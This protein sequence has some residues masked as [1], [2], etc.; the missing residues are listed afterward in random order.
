MP[1]FTVKEAVNT[2]IKAEALGA[3]YYAK[4]AKKAAAKPELKEM[5]ELLAKDEIEHKKQFEELSQLLPEEIP[6]ASEVDAL[7][8]EGVDIKKFFPSME[9]I[10]ENLK[11]SDVIKNAYDFEKESVLFYGGV[12]DLIGPSPILDEI[13]KIEKAHVTQLMKYALDDSKFRGVSD[14]WA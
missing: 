7:F 3:D 8:L 2:A 10:D 9:N 5:F 4:M 11:P 6:N 14:D 12:R 1:A 13:I